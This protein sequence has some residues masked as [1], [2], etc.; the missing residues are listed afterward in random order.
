MSLDS[1][2]IAKFEEIVKAATWADI[3]KSVTPM[4]P[5]LA[6]KD[7]KKGAVTT[8]DEA[9]EKLAVESLRERGFIEKN[10]T[11]LVGAGAVVIGAAA[12]ALAS[13]YLGGNAAQDADVVVSPA[14][15]HAVK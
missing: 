7:I 2:Q 9:L 12:G 6:M 15:L 11:V 8:V 10:K 4:I 5:T 1:A 13:M 14:K 3:S